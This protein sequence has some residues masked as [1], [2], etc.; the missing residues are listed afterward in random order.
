MADP[1]ERSSGIKVFL[2]NVLGKDLAAIIKND[3]CVFCNCMAKEFRDD[4][5]EREFTVS[6]LCQ[7]CQDKYLGVQE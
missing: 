7:Q 5:S 6:G 2:N 1:L 3:R 4:R